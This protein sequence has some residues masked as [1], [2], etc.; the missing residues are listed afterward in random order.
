MPTRSLERT[1]PLV[2]HRE[3][4]QRAW[5]DYNDHLNMAYY[6]LIFDHGTDALFDHLGL[7]WDHVRE[8]GGTTFTLE[9]HITYL[10]EVAL[11]D[12]V[13]IE[14]RILDFDEKRIHYVHAMFHDREGYLAAVNEL[15]TLH[16]D[17]ASRRTAPMPDASLAL[18][19]GYKA[20]HAGL[21]RP[22]GMSRT[23]GLHNRRKRSG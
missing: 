13:R 11:D 16:V 7:G 22:E 10:R 3:P 21:A 18:L 6:M 9:A 15:M 5:I 20:A 17:L 14:T 4:V 1:A 12:V 2:L 8:D 19:A 23:M